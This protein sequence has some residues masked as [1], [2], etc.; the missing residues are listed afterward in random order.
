[1]PP[2]VVVGFAKTNKAQIRGKKGHSRTGQCQSKGKC[3]CGWVI[4][5]KPKPTKKK[6]GK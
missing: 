5:P 3:Q 2:K 4:V 6:K 1:M